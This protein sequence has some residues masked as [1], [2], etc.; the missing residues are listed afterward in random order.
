MQARK[1]RLG[2]V[3]LSATLTTNILNP[4]TTSGG[5]G[6][7]TPNTY[8]VLKHIRIVNKTASP[9]AASLW[10]GTTGA[11]A[12]GT[13]V[14]AS[15]SVPANSHID[16]YDPGLRLDVGDFLVGGS[17]TANALTLFATGEI[18]LVG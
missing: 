12:A 14:M 4:P 17:G 5:V 18:G 2:P 9:A 10:I 7:G 11:N 16:L 15:L 6:A 13:E 8:I 1:F 3:A